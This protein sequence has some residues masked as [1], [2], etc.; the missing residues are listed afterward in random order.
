MGKAKNVY[1]VSHTHWDR[2]WYLT[3]ESFRI[4]LLDLIDRLLDILDS[5]PKYKAFMLDGQTI[6]LE[7]YLSLR[8]ENEDRLKKYIQEGRV[9]L[10]PWYVLP[11]EL[12]ISGEAHIRNYLV[13]DEMCQRLGGKMN[14]GYLP[15]AFGHPSQMPQL[16]KGLGMNELIFWRG[17]GPEISNTEFNWVGPDGTQ[18]YAINMPFGYGTAACL[19]QEREHFIKRIKNEVQRLEKMTEGE[20]VLLMNGVDHLAPQP[21]LSKML[22]DTKDNLDFNIFHT[23]MPEYVEAIKN[24]N[25]ELESYQGELRSPKRAYLLGGTISTRMYLKQKNF[26]AEQL[27]EK[28]AEPIASMMYINKNRYPEGELKQLWKYS[29]SNLPHDSICGC[30]VDEV[31]KEMQTRYKWIEELGSGLISKLVNNFTSAVRAEKD[32]HDGVLVVFN[33]LEHDRKDIVHATLEVEPQLIRKVDFDRGELVEYKVNPDRKMPV[34][35]KLFDTTDNEILCSLDSAEKVSVMKLSLDDQPHMYEVFRLKVAFLADKVPSLGY[36]T[37]RYDLIYDES[38][39]QKSEP[40][41]FTVEN[42]YFKITPDIDDG[43]LDILDKITGKT[44]LQCNRFVDSGDA[45]DEYTY[46]PPLHDNTV[47]LKE[48]T[49]RLSWLENSDLRQSIKIEG[50]MELPVGVTEDRKYRTAEIESCQIESVVAVYPGIRRIDICTR[51]DNKVKDH[52]LKVVF[53]SGICA[54][55]SSSEGIFSV[56]KH[57]V[58]DL[59]DTTDYSDWIEAPCGTNSQ[60]NFVDISDTNAGITI[61]NRGITESTVYNDGMQTYIALTLLRCVGWLSR[62]DLLLRKGNGGWTLPTP[63]AQCQG[64]YSFEY[65]IIPHQGNWSTGKTYV[66]AHN[67]A[68]PLYSAV[69]ENEGG[70]LPESFSYLTIDA[71]E[72]VI[73]AVK[74]AEQGNELI[75]R[76]FNQSDSKIRASMKLNFEVKEIFETKLNEIK[77][78]RLELSN[79]KVEL[80]F[81]PWQIK[82]ISLRIK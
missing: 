19:P 53:P 82:T 6:V 71:S 25:L 40:E 58:K 7:D 60:K 17:V 35:I 74:K 38:L 57:G 45:G 20:I 36:T 9:F 67:F 65:S 24:Q 47:T 59:N 44:Y 32:G 68:T 49:V 63:D 16:I 15:D 30:S 80:D 75:I 12:L 33:T 2:E 13:G 76:M 37:Y 39:L 34:A 77:I 3:R 43:T 14:L 29:L 41:D 51:F 10:G 56:D 42:E 28:L 8:P 50:L 48:A 55:Y 62:Q 73:S 27:L 31:H 61:A 81:E 52:L 79:E 70:S 23:T 46:S 64:L 21:F 66:E 78:R 4:M 5:D 1:L 22:E 26:Q 54:E 69:K 72:I 11:D 18:I